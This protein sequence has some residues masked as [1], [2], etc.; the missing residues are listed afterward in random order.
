[1]QPLHDLGCALPNIGRLAGGLL[2]VL[3]LVLPST[4]RS[5]EDTESPSVTLG[6]LVRDL[7]VGPGMRAV[8]QS[9][10]GSLFIG[11]KLR[12]ADFEGCDLDGVVFYQS[13]LSGASFKNARLRGMNTTECQY[14]QADFTDAIIND[15]V[16]ERGGLSDP[17]MAFWPH[18]MRLSEEQVKSTRSYKTKDLHRCVILGCK[19]APCNYTT[20]AD[21]P[22]YDFRGANLVGAILFHGDFT[23]C[24]FTDA[25]ISGIG[26]YYCQVTVDQL[27]S[28]QSF[29][30]R[31]L[32]H[33]ELHTRLFGEVD[34][35]GFDL[36][37]TC[38]SLGHLAVATYEKATISECWFVG[39]LTKEGLYSTTNYQQG[40]LQKITFQYINMSGWDLAR[41]DLTGCRFFNCNFAGTLFDNA[42]ITDVEFA[43]IGL[44]GCTGLTAEQ[45]K[46]TWNYRHGRMAGI[47]LP[48]AVAEALGLKK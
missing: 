35:S 47:K 19:T 21:A 44:G 31:V 25:R 12:N 1:M 42:V 40:R 30:S 39:G 8:G 10:K 36:T 6:P 33:A 43:R 24:D 29:K 15:I 22:A 37:G 14:D 48:P 11:Q 2:V 45:I 13:D 32:R 16:C 38:F 28:T 26:L 7:H 34:F 4:G 20:K 41:K 23:K 46:S 9:L 3:Y 27:A 18:H 17:P 5:Q